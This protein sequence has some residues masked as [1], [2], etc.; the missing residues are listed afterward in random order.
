ML[1]AKARRKKYNLP[2][3]VLQLPSK[4]VGARLIGSTISIAFAEQATLPLHCSLLLL[5]LLHSSFSPLALV[6]SRLVT[7]QCQNFW[8]TDYSK[9]LAL[10]KRFCHLHNFQLG[11]A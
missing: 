4:I 9:L 1:L 2:R 7:L 8:P 10:P 5:N 11:S 3:L 6:F